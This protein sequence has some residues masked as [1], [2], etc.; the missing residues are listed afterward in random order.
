V[1]FK[2]NRVVSRVTLRTFHAGD[3]RWPHGAARLLADENQGV[4]IDDLP[5]A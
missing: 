3:L 4:M 2:K 1:N 5:S